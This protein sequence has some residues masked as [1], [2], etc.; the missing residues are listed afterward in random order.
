[1]IDGGISINVQDGDSSMSFHILKNPNEILSTG[2]IQSIIVGVERIM[3]HFMTKVRRISDFL[4][5][6]AMKWV[7]QAY[8]T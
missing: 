7:F 8:R 1:M 2:M 3:F 5:K 6:L 4:S